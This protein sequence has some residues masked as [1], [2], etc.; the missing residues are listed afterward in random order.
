MLASWP[1]RLFLPPHLPAQNTQ[2]VGT[3]SPETPPHGS[4]ALGSIGSPWPFRPR[5]ICGALVPP[6]SGLGSHL[7]CICP[8]RHASRACFEL[9]SG[10]WGA[11]VGG[12]SGGRIP[13]H[14]AHHSLSLPA[15]L[16][17]PQGPARE[18][19][20]G[21]PE[22]PEYPWEPSPWSLPPV[23][24]IGGSQSWPGFFS[25]FWVDT[26]WAGSLLFFSPLGDS[27]TLEAMG[28]LA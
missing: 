13:C 8:L 5:V 18:Q 16:R 22:A 1:P 23:Q 25:L 6:P 19:Q 14:C 24:S 28:R 7:L 4:L 27:G 10:R 9:G 2:P 17:S 20:A 21:L 26:C 3:G 15:G 12:C 11:G